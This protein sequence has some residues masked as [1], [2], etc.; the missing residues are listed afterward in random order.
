V[1]GVLIDDPRPLR[2]AEVS[3]H[4]QSYSFPAHHPAM[5]SFLGVPIL[6]RGRAWGNIYLT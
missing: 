5:R 6:I 1:L 2:L 3:E 4:P